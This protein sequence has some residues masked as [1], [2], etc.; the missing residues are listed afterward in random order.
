[1]A[2]EA[3]GRTA[4]ALP[5]QPGSLKRAPSEELQAPGTP[6]GLGSVR[7]GDSKGGDAGAAFCSSPGT[8]GGDEA[9]SIVW[10]PVSAME[11]GEPAGVPLGGLAD[12]LAGSSSDADQPACCGKEAAHRQGDP[13]EGAHASAPAS[14][15]GFSGGPVLRLRPSAGAGAAPANGAGGGCFTRVGDDG[16]GACVRGGG[17][18]G[19]AMGAAAQASQVGMWVSDLDAS[20]EGPDPVDA[21]GVAG[22]G[23]FSISPQVR[24]YTE[25]EFLWEMQMPACDF[26]GTC[27]WASK[28]QGMV[29]IPAKSCKPICERH[30]QS[31]LLYSA[32]LVVSHAGSLPTNW[33][34]YAWQCW[35]PTWK[36][37]PGVRASCRAGRHAHDQPHDEPHR[38]PGAA[39]A[40][41][42]RGGVRGSRSRAGPCRRRDA[43]DYCRGA[44]CG[45][46]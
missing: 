38:Q 3:S 24:V 4:G 8:P 44:G 34:S 36:Q 21:G 17:S 39:A 5:Q 10:E 30:A 11:L 16:G 43:A 6:P 35:P 19:F 37:C 27:F 12:G 31:A 20:G 22:S 1:M 23:A 32:A 9:S 2:A 40:A 46:L 13:A 25:P 28:R 42:V 26:L 33:R 41:A 15:N 45:A 14:L 7:T 29:A 18:G